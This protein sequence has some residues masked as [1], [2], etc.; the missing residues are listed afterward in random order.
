MAS[1]L[2][3]KYNVKGAG[4]MVAVVES[5]SCIYDALWLM[6]NTAK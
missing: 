4:I 3:L 5:M 1:T 6:P 2:Y